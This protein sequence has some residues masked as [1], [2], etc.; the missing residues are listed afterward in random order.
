[1]PFYEEKRQI[2]LE[3]LAPE[4]RGTKRR[5]GLEMLTDIDTAQ[6]VKEVYFVRV[7]KGDGLR[8]DDGFFYNGKKWIPP[9][10]CLVYVFSE[11]EVIGV[12]AYFGDAF[13]RLFHFDTFYALDLPPFRLVHKV[14]DVVLMSLTGNFRF[15][16]EA[17]AKRN[18]FSS[19]PS[20]NRLKF[21]VGG[22]FQF[23][24]FWAHGLVEPQQTM[25]SNA[26]L[27]FGRYGPAG[28]MH[29]LLDTQVLKVPG[30]VGGNIYQPT[31]ALQG[32]FV[33]KVEI[34]QEIWIRHELT[35]DIGGV[36]L[37]PANNSGSIYLFCEK[38]GEI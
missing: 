16:V 34:G 7:G 25:I 19:L 5:I 15:L 1:M 26:S 38:I 12:W 29:V 4:L 8:Y 22:F 23:Y 11:K 36:P 10:D 18:F 37:T 13:Y 35:Q 24:V 17:K 27:F 14:S 2:V 28:E 9:Q 3:D 30:T 33:E 20:S 32:L 31:I 21:F 6:A